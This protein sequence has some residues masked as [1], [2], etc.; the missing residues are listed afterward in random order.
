MAAAGFLSWISKFIMKSSYLLLF[1]LLTSDTYHFHVFL[2]V[3]HHVTVPLEHFITCYMRMFSLAETKP[4]LQ[5]KLRLKGN[6]LL[7]LAPFLPSDTMF[8]ATLFYS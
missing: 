7:S 4:D 6:G 2:S 3:S 5:Q 8:P 1:S